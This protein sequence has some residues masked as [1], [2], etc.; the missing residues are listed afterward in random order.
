MD[1]D[2][3]VVAV[4]LT[5]R[6]RGVRLR[7]RESTSVLLKYIWGKAGEALRK[8]GRVRGQWEARESR[9]LQLNKRGGI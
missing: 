1:V 9:K 7:E 3:R 2:L 4:K 8:S 6:F 5:N